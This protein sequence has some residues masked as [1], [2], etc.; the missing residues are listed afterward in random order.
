MSRKYDHEFKEKVAREAISV[1]NIAATAKKYGINPNSV[2]KWKKD[3]ETKLGVGEIQNTIELEDEN[4][5]AAL[6][7]QAID[8]K[9][10]LDLAKKDLKEAIILIG[11]KDLYI[12]KLKRNVAN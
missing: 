12:K 2:S 8:L 4:N 11:E 6:K 1:N 7:R 10:Q 5:I 9:R 3:L